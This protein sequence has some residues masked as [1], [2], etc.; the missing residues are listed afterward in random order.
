MRVIGPCWGHREPTLQFSS[1]D[2]APGGPDF[3]WEGEWGQ[4]HPDS[5]LEAHLLRLAKS[6]HTL[7]RAGAGETD[8]KQQPVQPGPFHPLHRGTRGS[9]QLGP[10]G[11]AHSAWPVLPAGGHVFL[12]RRAS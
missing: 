5:E 8:R 1:S 3:S 11:G 9:L 7:L 10:H 6:Y 4:R 2:S 12:S